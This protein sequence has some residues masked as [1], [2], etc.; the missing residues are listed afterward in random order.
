MMMM[1]IMTMMYGRWKE[2]DVRSE[3]VKWTYLEHQGPMT[4]VMTTDGDVDDEWWMG[5]VT[6]SN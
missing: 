4:M 5:G 1:I 6:D 2:S 3:G